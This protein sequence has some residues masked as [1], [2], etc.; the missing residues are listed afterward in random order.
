MGG[1]V[2]YRR[3]A[4]AEMEEG[5]ADEGEAGSDEFRRRSLQT[6]GVH[7]GKPLEQQGDAITDA[8]TS[9]EQQGDATF[10][11]EEDDFLPPGSC[12]PPVDD[13]PP[14]CGDEKPAPSS[15]GRDERHIVE[16]VSFVIEE[17][18]GNSE[19]TCLYRVRV[20][21]EAVP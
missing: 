3:I 20:H 13:E 4:A 7:G 1:S 19:Y 14:S 8:I 2:E 21:G 16:A 6:F 15:E 10:E 18:W 9:S 11:P 17:N 12:R 5:S